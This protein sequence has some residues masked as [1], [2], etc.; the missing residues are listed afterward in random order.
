MEK[1]LVLSMYKQKEKGKCFIIRKKKQ[2]RYLYVVN[3]FCAVIEICFTILRNF[4]LNNHYLDNNYKT[5]PKSKSTTGNFIYYI[6]L[7][8]CFLNVSVNYLCFYFYIRYQ[9]NKNSQPYMRTPGKNLLDDDYIN[10]E[11]NKKSSNSDVNAFLFS[12][13]KN[14]EEDPVAVEVKAEDRDSL[15]FTEFES[16]NNNNVLLPDDFT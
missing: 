11:S 5:I 1:S 14:K 4:I 13:A 8:V 9:Y 16:G 15:N 7:I 10:E 2:I 3:L 6:Y 12:L